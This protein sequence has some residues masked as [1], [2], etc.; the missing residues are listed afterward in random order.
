MF[1][2]RE[3]IADSLMA[4]SHLSKSRSVSFATLVVVLFQAGCESPV[5]LFL[6]FLC[7]EPLDVPNSYG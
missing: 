4:R 1:S 2:M 7:E 6:V 3:S 5:S